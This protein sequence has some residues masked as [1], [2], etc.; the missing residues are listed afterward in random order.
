MKWISV[1]SFIFL[2]SHSLSPTPGCPRGVARALIAECGKF[3]LLHAMLPALKAAGH[4][5]L[6]FSQ[7]TRL[8]DLLEEYLELEGVSVSHPLLKKNDEGRG[9]S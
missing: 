3:G 8:L 9:Y 5:V 1:Q 2:P 4:K 7:M 6:I